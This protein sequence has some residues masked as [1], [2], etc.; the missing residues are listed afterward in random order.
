MYLVKRLSK[1]KG[2]GRYTKCLRCRPTD[3][4]GRR[5]PQ[6]GEGCPP[7]SLPQEG[8]GALYQIRWQIRCQ[9]VNMHQGKHRLGGP[10]RMSVPLMAGLLAH[11]RRI[12]IFHGDFRVA[13]PSACY[14]GRKPQNCPKWLGEGAKGVLARWRKGLPRVSCTTATLFCTSATLFCTSATGFWS[15]YAKTPFAPSDNH[16][17]QF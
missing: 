7:D 4:L 9:S 6:R 12:F 5:G 10:K 13:T 14:R 15:T 11:I 3:S 1:D 2:L 16:F 17:G 8:G